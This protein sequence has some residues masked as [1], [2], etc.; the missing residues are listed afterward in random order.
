MQAVYSQV[1]AMKQ[2]HE[3]IS[4]LNDLASERPR[5]AL[6]AGI[7]QESKHI[8]DLETE[9]RELRIVL[10]EQQNAID[11]IMSKYRQQ[12]SELIRQKGYDDRLLESIDANNKVVER[13]SGQVNEMRQ[14]MRHAI[15]LDEE[16]I[17]KEE[18]LIA[19]LV[20][21]NKGLRELLQISGTHGSYNP[22]P[23]NGPPTE[24]EDKEVQTEAESVNS[25]T[26]NTTTTTTPN[27]NNSNSN[28]TPK[29]MKNHNKPS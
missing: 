15:E 1:E 25:T 23:M 4:Q 21:E 6:V 17:V 24:T 13:N 22:A 5:L 20:T 2:Y 16:S 29:K 9:N 14:I 12:I 7:Q 18:E 10:E 19:R 27:K 11:L 28:S 26:T 8:M 3:E